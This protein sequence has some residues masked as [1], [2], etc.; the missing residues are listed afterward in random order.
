VCLCDLVGLFFCSSV[1]TIQL[2][3]FPLVTF[4]ERLL[5]HI[6]MDRLLI[7]NVSQVLCNL[8]LQPIQNHAF[9][10][11]FTINAQKANKRIVQN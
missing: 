8:T 4:S 5:Q 2:E 3:L 6:P 1:G 7:I 10:V 9:I 11:F